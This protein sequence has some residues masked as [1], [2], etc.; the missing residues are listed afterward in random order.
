MTN[1]PEAIAPQPSRPEHF[2]FAIHAGI[3]IAVWVL[4][5]AAGIGFE[6]FVTPIDVAYDRWPAMLLM[7]PLFLTVGGAHYGPRGLLVLPGLLSMPLIA[8]CFV[9]VVLKPTS[10]RCSMLFSVTAF[11]YAG[12]FH[13]AEAVLSV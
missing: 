5:I 11:F 10:F 12:L 8:L 1:D 7:S 13:K 2:R 3:A 4:G 6:M 9:S